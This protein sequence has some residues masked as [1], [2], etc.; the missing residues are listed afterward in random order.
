MKKA[1]LVILFLA[2]GLAYAQDTTT[3]TPP[4]DAGTQPAVTPADQP[5]AAP[6]D[7]NN[8]P[9]ISMG[10]QPTAAASS[11][12][13]TSW[14]AGVGT[15]TIDG[16]QWTRLSLRPDIPIWKFG[17]CLDIEL[18]INDSGQLSD[19]G[20]K[21]NNGK[22]AFESISRKIYYLRFAHAG[23]PVY[24]K[25]GA[26]DNVTLGYGLI[27]NNYTNAIDYPEVKRLGL[28]FQLNDL[29]A[30]KIGVQ[31][32][33]NNFMDFQ[34]GGALVGLRPNVAPLAITDIPVLK[35][36]KVGVTGVMDL[37][38]R[39]ALR[40]A[41]GDKVPDWVD[42]APADKNWAIYHPEFPGLDTTQPGIHGA[43][44]TINAAYQ[45]MND[46]TKAKYGRFTSGADRF[47]IWGGDLGLPLYK[48]KFIGWDVYSQYAK[49]YDPDKNEPK[50]AEGW[51]STPLGTI[52][53]VGPVTL[54]GEYLYFK[55][56]FERG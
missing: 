40:D 51:G 5:A 29:G 33:V 3:Q 1:L 17:I 30:L 31:T 32:M 34:K 53:R 35:N 44:D 8:K 47:M 45:V 46:S 14:T 42:A 16:K 54:T 48:S 9:A 11:G 43:V 10:E 22:E 39:S 28:E 37:N 27:M 6:A 19:K 23:D 26:I 55:D 36:L 50:Q 7:T 4:A 52:F 20:W 25:V 41:D 21:F 56:Q 2:F 18:F 13:K 24:A 15:V 49:I 12:N 38:Q